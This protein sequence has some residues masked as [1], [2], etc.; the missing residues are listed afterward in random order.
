[1]SNSTSGTSKQSISPQTTGAVPAKKRK[2]STPKASKSM[3]M[4]YFNFI[5]LESWFVPREHI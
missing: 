4:V 2:P 1:M 3:S 5:F